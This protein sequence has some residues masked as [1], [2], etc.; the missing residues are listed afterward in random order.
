MNA[1]RLLTSLS[2]RLTAA[3]ML[4]VL[5]L[6]LAVAAV[7]A[8]DTGWVNPANN[9]ADTG[10]DNNGF[11]V[12]PANAYTDG[13]G[14]AANMDG[15][16]DRH[17]YWGYNFGAIPSDAVIQGI[18]VRLDW[19]LSATAG[20]NS[21]SVELSWDG[22]TSWTAAQTTTTEPTAE[23]T[24]ILGGTGHTW[25]RGNSWTAAQL[26][27]TNFRVR[28]T[29]TCTGFLAGCDQRDFYLDWVPV[30]VTYVLPT[31]TVLTSSSNP[32]NFGD[33]VTFTATVSASSGTPAGNVE[34]RDG[35]TVLG[36]VALNASGQAT[37]ATS[38]L[39]AGSHN[40]TAVYVGNATYN[41]STSNTV[42][43]GVNQAPAITSANAVTFN[44]GAAGTFTVTATGFPVPTLARSGAAL[45]SGVTFNPATGVLSGTPASGTVGTYNLVFT[46]TNAGG[47]ATQNFTL[48]VARGNQTINF[49]QPTTPVGFGATFTVNPTAT[50]GLPVA[51]VVTSGP[52]TI[53]AA[54]GPYT[55]TTTGLGTCRL[56]A[57]Q[58][59]DASYN[60]AASVFRDVVVQPA[61]TVTTITSSVNPSVLGQNVIF[62]VRVTSPSGG[63]PTGTVTITSCEWALLFCV[64]ATTQTWGTYP[65]VGGV[66]TI[67]RADL[68]VARYGGN[69]IPSRITV[70]YGGGGNYGGSST[71]LDQTVN[72]ASTAVAL[73]SS[74]NPSYFGQAV[75][76]T[77][78]VT[79][80]PPGAGTVNGGT[81]TLYEGATVLGSGTVNASGVITFTISNLARGTHPITAHFVGTNDFGTSTSPVLNQVV[82]RDSDTSL[83]SSLNPSVYGNTVTFTATVTDP[84]G[85]GTPTGNVSFYDGATLLGTSTL[86]GSA[87][88][89]FNTSLLSAGSHNI[90]ATYNGNTFYVASTSSVLVQVV[91]PTA[92][93]V[94]ADNQSITYGDANPPFTYSFSGFV[95][96]QTLATSDVTGAASCSSTATPTSP[97]G[98]YPITCAIG[99]LNSNNYTFNFADGVLTILQKALTITAQNQGKTYGFT[100]NFTGSEFNSSGL[101]NADTVTSVTLTS[102]GAAAGAPNGSYPIVPSA[103]VGTGLSNYSITYVNGTLTVGGNLLVITANDYVG[104][105]AKTYGSTLTLPGTAFTYALAGGGSLLPGES[106]DSVTLTSFGTPANAP[107]G[108]Y[109]IVPSNAVGTGLNNYVI[110]YQNGQLEVNRALLT[111]DP[112]SHTKLYGDTFSGYTGTFTGLFPFDNTIT[113]I[114]DSAGA[115]PTATVTAPG[116][117]YPITV[118]F[119]DPDGRLGNYTL[120]LD[121]APAATLTVLRRTLT[122]LPTDRSKVYGDT[123]TSADFSGTITGIQNSDNIT[124]TY[125]SPLGDPPTAPVGPYNIDATVFDPDNRLPNY[126]LDQRVGTLTV[127]R[128][129]L[130]VT[131]NSQSKIYG[132]VFD[133][134]NFTGSVVGLQNSDVITPN[135]DSLGEPATAPAGT[136]NITVLPLNDPGNVLSNYNVTYNIGTLAVLRR[137]L[138]FTPDPQTKFYGENFT[139]FTG[140]VTGLQNGDPITPNYSSPGSIPTA[141][142]AGSP[143]PIIITLSDPSNRLGN[144]NYTINSAELTVLQRS[145]VVTP[146]DQSKPYGTWFTAFTGT[147]TGIQNGDNITAN[148]SSPGSPPAAAVGPHPITATL[149]DPTGKLGNYAVTLN[150]GTLTV[151]TLTL[152]VTAHNQSIVYGNPDPAFTFTYTGFAAGDTASVI[153]TPPTC[154]VVPPH[155]NVGSYP[156]TCSGGV[157]NTYTF[158][159]VDGTLN[160]TRRN[161]VVTPADRIKI[162]GAV[163]TNLSGTITGIQNSETI[164]ATYDSA[165]AVATAAVGTYPIS[166]TLNAAPGV[167]DNYN[168]IANTG[169]L[170]VDPRALIV[171]PN[172]QTKLYGDTFSAY[173]ATVNGIQNGDPITLTYASAGADPTATVG[174]YPITVTLAPAA[175]LS[176]YD[177]TINPATLTVTRRPLVVTPDNQTKAFGVNF[178]AFTGSITGIQNGENITAT[179]SSTGAP[180]AAPVG[181]YPITASL[182]D[183]GGFLPNYNVTYNTGTLTVGNTILT[184]T[185]DN[186]T[187]TYG[188]PDPVFT[189]AY[190]G[191]QSGDDPSDLTTEPTCQVLPA[192][193]AVGSFPITCSGGVD[194][195]YTFNYVGATLS[196]TPRDLTV[197]PNNQVKVYGS[198]FTAFTGSTTGIQGADNITVTYSSAGAAPTASVAGSPYPITATLN[199]PNN[200]L[201]NYNVTL[202]TGTLTVTQR[203]LIATSDDKTKPYGTVFT[204]FTGSVVGI[205]NG[206]NIT[207]AYAS[208]GAPAAAIAASYPITITLN[209]PDNRLPNYNV[210]YNEGTLVVG[211]NTL[212]ITPADKTKVYGDTFT[213]FTGTIVGLQPGDNITATYTSTGAAATATVAGS[214]YTITAILNDPDGRL[215][216]Y[217]VLLNTGSLTV[218]RRPLVVTPNNHAKVFGTTFTAFTGVITGIQNGEN[219]TATY[220]S[221]G[222]PAPAAVGSYPITA[223]LNDPAGRLPNY[224]VT[225]NEGT[226]TVGNTILTVTANNQTKV[227]GDPDPIFTFTYAGFQAGDGPGNLTTLPT[228]QV[229]P[230]HNAVGT[231]PITCSGGLDDNY[232]F[233]YIG[234]TL[235]ITPRALTVTPDNH[236]KLYGE[237]FTAFTG[238]LNGLQA[239]DNITATYAS[240]GAAAAAIVNTYPITVAAL[241]DPNGRL[242]NY[243]VTNNTGTLTVTPRPLSVTSHDKLKFYGSLFTNFTGLISGIQNNDNI[244]ASY[245]STGGPMTAIVGDYPIAITINDPGNRLPNY[246]V[247]TNP[248]TLTVSPRDLVIT[249]ADKTKSFGSDFTNFSGTIIGLRNGD[250]ITATYT[251]TGAPAPAP[252]GSYPIIA[253]LAD[254]NN[255]LSNYDVSANN[256]TL[257]VNMNSQAITITIPAPATAGFNDTFT[258]AAVA[259]S[260]LPV[261]YSAGGTACTNV[262]ATFTMVSNTGVCIVQYDQPGDANYPPAAQMTQTVQV[263]KAS[264]FITVTTPAPATALNGTSF[265]VAATASSSLPVN[266]ISNGN[267]SGN[268]NGTANISMGNGSGICTIIYAQPGDAYFL[269]ATSITDIV[270]VTNLPV[271]TLNPVD[272]WILPGATATFTTAATGNPNPTVQWQVSSDGGATFTNIPV[273]TSTTYSL[274]NAQLADNGLQYRAV[275]TNTE[276]SSNSTV[277]ILHVDNV[278]PL[279]TTVNSVSDTGDGRLDEME[280]A[281]FAITRLLAI[282]NEN[283]NNPAGNNLPDD[284]TNTAN[285]LLVRDNGDGIQ[286]TTCSAGIIGGDIAVTIDLVSYDDNGGSG[287]YT[288]T[289]YLNGTTALPNGVYRLIVCGTTSITD[290]AGNR[291]AGNG[292][293]AGTDFT[294]NFVV[295]VPSD[296]GGGDGSSSKPPSYTGFLIPVTGFAPDTFT[297]LPVQPVEKAYSSYNGLILEIPRLKVKVEIVGIPVSNKTWDVSW[298]GNNA[299]YLE[300]SAFPTM[301][302]N[303]VLTAHVWDAY[304]QPGTFYGLKDLVYGDK[305]LIRAWGKVYTYEVRSRARV[306]PNSIGTIMRHERLSWLTLV[307]CE[308]Y[309]DKAEKYNFRRIVRAVLVSVTDEK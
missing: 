262:G 209:D 231:F 190:S 309:N 296:G 82:R 75:T 105:N 228:C 16:G 253:T 58:A 172:N 127:T 95:N 195:N 152:T 163:I 165:G 201:G 136:Y 108:T 81:V 114:Y 21:M 153:D 110:I 219:I 282:F 53:T 248:G 218:T 207:P 291:L 34:F 134:A 290:V 40:I 14:N 76:F 167:L 246:T 12:N 156:I 71:T 137:D 269:P 212:I 171:S 44:V 168:I 115:P 56:T 157:D 204:A 164:T 270:S 87:V 224:S 131:S 70:N 238:T 245:A 271:I 52:C 182:N 308:D 303:S 155:T 83:S 77:A 301:L 11:E 64:P 22:G 298:L 173:T 60:P 198:N 208:A 29:S 59:G 107:V 234:A 80:S 128:R 258:V 118:T 113:P 47:T 217:T 126:T 306:Y 27:T 72:T 74:I 61:A 193:N 235:T 189:F 120:T 289:L 257:T 295:A 88:A 148:Y 15:T 25:G 304:N 236:S 28:V 10:G 31:T 111:F 55:V 109:P 299:G 30:R 13:A 161:L 145:L 191:F 138:V 230:A 51:V 188:D 92:L 175:L 251:S 169:T 42:V 254:P 283:L 242:G 46:A 240:A 252:V 5:L 297:R 142:V 263:V 18:E 241:N 140:T 85:F 20:T 24:T 39:S 37:Y 220:S 255:R 179:Y 216:N 106:L 256:G 192:H 90:T 62:T 6:T 112:G 84:G 135:Y 178:T 45:P 232:V 259:T 160:V 281:T 122:V 23:A 68:P 284:V 307:T 244:T 183:P 132:E 93:L 214:P 293:T 150:Q 133:P 103:A 125:D 67:N 243:T 119:N 261:V 32:S 154:T 78:T 226:L 276:G 144:Y 123:L 187:K 151:N 286:T 33:S 8:A 249:P 279:V 147:I 205:Q 225:L 43:Q 162:Y 50:S 239:S 130:V 63:T 200:R 197:T 99:S 266:I 146:T 247:T 79:V 268:G 288:S 48:T 213:A 101:I 184:V 121:P 181:T 69:I 237:A 54:P 278:P 294:R 117:V 17:R 211:G 141:T 274:P 170:T 215:P 277:A 89:T 102:A 86:N 222:A 7:Q 275:F 9:A 100:L 202:N 149:N 65:L 143:Y 194:D 292:T 1:K 159:Y 300:G 280:I 229:L 41:T 3:T 196:I 129:S 124:A 73:T 221:T 19:W 98:T 96:G 265:T 116:P 273:A 38:A 264:Q 285:Y 206:D 287:P 2:T 139:A 49:T 210:S 250:N 176:N 35:A 186:Q 158:D 174:P 94:T 104:A 305:V 26:S 203:A 66:A 177:I 97:I 223:S 260:S 272:A 91:N 185:A 302:G 227:Y 199:D 166:A 36:T 267:C 180:A 233:N 57:S 4:T